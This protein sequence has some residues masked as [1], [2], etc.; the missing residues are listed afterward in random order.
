MDFQQLLNSL[1]P[2]LGQA[3]VD[4][5]EGV[6]KDLSADQDKPWAQTAL[7]LLADAVGAHGMAGVEMA[8]KAID[9]LFENEV[10]NIDFA[11]PRTASDFVAKL[12]NAEADDQS[13]A[14]DFFVKVGDAFGQ[15]FAG[16]IKGLV[17]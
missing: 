5:L 8:R 16:M 17:A 14:R 13:A 2:T 3:G 6:F 7:A 10:P 12:Q 9:A 11:S 15:I 1:L 4:T